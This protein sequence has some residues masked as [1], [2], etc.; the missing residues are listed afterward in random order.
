MNNRNNTNN[1]TRQPFKNHQPGSKKPRP[2]QANNKQ[3][4]HRNQ[5]YRGGAM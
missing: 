5:S 3:Q 1:N 2:N 4:P